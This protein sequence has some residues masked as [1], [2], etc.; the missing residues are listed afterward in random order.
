[1]WCLL[2]TI[3]EFCRHFPP[4]LY[5]ATS[6]MFCWSGGRRILI[7]LS[8][9]YGIVYYYNGAQWYEQVLEVGRLDQS[10]SL[11]GLA[12]YLLSGSVSSV[13]VVDHKKR[14]KLC[15]DIVLLNNRI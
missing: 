15:N 14:P 3:I 12:L 2:S 1:M 9:C 6:E 5:L 11:L 7:K 10:L 13:F 4:Y 8:L